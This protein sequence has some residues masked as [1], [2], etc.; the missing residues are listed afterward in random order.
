MK[1][2]G[3]RAKWGLLCPHSWY[4]FLKYARVGHKRVSWNHEQCCQRNVSFSFLQK[5]KFLFSNAIMGYFVK[6]LP[7]ICRK[8]G[9]IHYLKMLYHMYLQITK[10]LCVKHFPYTS[11]KKDKFMLIQ[12][13]WGQIWTTCAS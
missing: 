8:I 1:I 6:E 5:I 3:F 4:S 11:C 7:K 9:A 10:W 2:H 13:E 12:L